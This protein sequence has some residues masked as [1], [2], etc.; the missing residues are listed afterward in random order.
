MA[1]T[2]FAAGLLNE[3]LA[4]NA[5]ANG[6]VC[7]VSCNLNLVKGAVVFVLAVV[8]ALLYGAFNRGIGRL[9][10]HFRDLTK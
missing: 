10:I 2:V 3:R 6:G 4:V 8:F 7:F 9:V 1:I 5:L